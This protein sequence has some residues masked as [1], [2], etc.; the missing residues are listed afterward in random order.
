MYQTSMRHISSSSMI[1]KGKINPNR[2]VEP[3][4]FWHTWTMRVCL[5]SC[6]NQTDT[7]FSSREVLVITIH[8][9]QA[10]STF[11]R[12]PFFPFKKTCLTSFL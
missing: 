4:V 8:G 12:I 5:S 2:P 1:H 3:E 9:F 11:V 6:E 10:V 7:V